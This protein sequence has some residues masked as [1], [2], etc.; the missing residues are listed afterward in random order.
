MCAHPVSFNE[1]VITL[2]SINGLQ[3]GVR[4]TQCVSFLSRNHADTE[5]SGISLIQRGISLQDK[6]HCCKFYYFSEKE[7]TRNKAPLYF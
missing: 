4:C 3:I 5:Q 1:N 2:R 6:C 7:K